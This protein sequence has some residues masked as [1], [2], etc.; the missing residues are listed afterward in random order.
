M[1]RPSP[2]LVVSILALLVASTG[3]AY[4][5]SGGVL[6][7]GQ[8]NLSQRLTVLRDPSGPAL[9]LV[10]PPGTSPLEVSNPQEVLH[11]N[12]NYLQSWRASDLGAVESARVV[13]IPAAPA[14]MNTVGH[15]SPCILRYFGAV[16][17]LSNASTVPDLV[18][19]LSP[20]QFEFVRDLAA[21]VTAPPG[22]AQVTVGID[23]LTQPADL[24]QVSGCVI[25]SSIAPCT[26]NLGLQQIPSASPICIEI[27]EIYGVGVGPVPAESVLVGFRM[28]RS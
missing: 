4:A 2:S 14:C 28:T 7:L 1:R 21:Q 16:A 13:S 20:N 24:H 25:T 23:Y 27:D 18:Y 15:E 12:A 17:G 26:N 9:D 22:P 3:T 10:A 6:I 11:L 5:T 19:S 8:G